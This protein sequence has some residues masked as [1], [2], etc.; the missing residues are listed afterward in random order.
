VELLQHVISIVESNQHCLLDRLEDSTQ[1]LGICFSVTLAL[2]S[3]EVASFKAAKLFT[4]SR[5]MKI[6][7]GKT[8]FATGA[9]HSFC[10]LDFEVIA[11]YPS[12][13]SRRDRNNKPSAWK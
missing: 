2:Y 13:L 8:L 3:A 1:W 12:V 10:K 9:S 6:A 11:I 4:S 5:A 7:E